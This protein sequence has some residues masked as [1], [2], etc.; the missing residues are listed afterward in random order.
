MNKIVN[1]PALGMF[2]SSLIT[3][4]VVVIHPWYLSKREW[5]KCDHEIRRTA[6]YPL[7]HV[8]FTS[9][10][11]LSNTWLVAHEEKKADWSKVM[12]CRISQESIQTHYQCSPALVSM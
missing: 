2:K 3:S 5:L 9:L 12:N 8:A 4:A 1:I 10:Q 11:K 6:P 7:Q